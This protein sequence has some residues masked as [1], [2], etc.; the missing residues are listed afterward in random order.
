[1]NIRSI[2]H[3]FFLML[4][5]HATI[6]GC[7]GTSC[8]SSLCNDIPPRK[9]NESFANTHWL[10]RAQGEQLGIFAGAGIG[11]KINLFCPGR[12]YGILGFTLLY[13]HNF[14]YTNN[15]SYFGGQ[16]SG[17]ITINNSGTYDIR[18]TDLGLANQSYRG[19]FCLRPTIRNAV[20]NTDLFVGWDDVLTRLY[21]R[22]RVPV[23]FSKWNIGLNQAYQKAPLL[24]LPLDGNINFAANIPPFLPQGSLDSW[25]IGGN[26]AY[27]L[28]LFDAA[29]SFDGAGIP[30]T[31]YIDGGALKNQPS[32]YP[33]LI[34]G[35]LWGALSEIGVADLPMDIGYNIISNERSMLGLSFHAVAPVGTKQ[36]DDVIFT[37]RIGY[38]RWQV[39]GQINAQHT[40]YECGDKRFT[41]YL[42]GFVTYALPTTEVRLLGLKANNS[43]QFNHYL[44]LK[45][46]NS[47]GTL[48]ALERAANLLYQPI[49]LTGFINSDIAVWGQYQ[50]GPYDVTIGYNF[51]GRQAE[52]F[53]NAACKKSHCKN[54]DPVQNAV[55]GNTSAYYVIKGTTLLYDAGGINTDFY[56]KT[57][58]NINTLG[59]MLTGFANVQT[60]A[61]TAADVVAAP[62]LHPRMITNAVFGYL[63]YNWEKQKHVAPFVGLGGQVEWGTGNAA[64]HMWGIFA[65]TGFAY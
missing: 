4:V 28:P 17:L 31:Y 63:G 50:H 14:H 35:L 12:T 62:A 25:T 16:E 6:I 36:D 64:M 61:F 45:K 65:K 37:P 52:G 10:Q 51:V 58:S 15:S 55:F 42:A 3:L 48:I 22:V 47:N 18:A 32:D 30:N 38:G 24:T 40:F 57:D 9:C 56:A 23:T 33:Q 49:N 26:P 11:D 1:M 41:V 21:T 27:T 60:H 53:I 46:F 2:L 7:A 8:N 5:P 29:Q 54:L 39:G 59:T 19:T 20:V 13:E 34:H 44:L 43:Y